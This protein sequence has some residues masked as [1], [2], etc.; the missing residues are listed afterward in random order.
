M[1]STTAKQLEIVATYQTQAFRFENANGDVVVGKARQQID[2]SDNGSSGDNGSNG[3]THGEII[4]IKG[5]EDQGCQLLRN[6][7]YRFFGRWRDYTNRRT[8]KTERQFHFDSY[9][10]TEPAGRDAVVAYLLDAAMHAR[11]RLRHMTGSNSSTM[12]FGPAKAN[13]IW[14]AFGED[15]IRMCREQPGETMVAAGIKSRKIAEALQA[16][17]ESRKDTERCVMDLMELFAGRSIPKKIIQP[18]LRVWGN[19]AAKL[20]RRNPYLLMRFRGVGFATADKMYLGLGHDPKR[21]K[22]LAYRIWHAID[23]AS[24]GDTWNNS[25]TVAKSITGGWSVDNVSRAMLLAR[26]A[27]LIRVTR[28]DDHGCICDRGGK[29][30]IAVRK[31]AD[32]E[33]K[34]AEIIA[35]KVG[36]HPMW[37]V[38]ENSDLTDHQ[39]EAIDTALRGPISLLIGSPGCGKTYSA[40]RII[41]TVIEQYGRDSIA[42]AAPTGKA[43]VRLSESL[44]EAGIEVKAKTIH[45][46]LRV[47]EAGSNGGGWRFHHREDQP[48]PFGFLVID[49]SSMIDVDLMA[50]L[51]RA[52]T[53]ETQLLFIGDTNQLAPV[54]HGAPLRDMIRAGLPCGELRE[55]LRNDGG[56]VQAC[57]DIRDGKEFRCGGNL[58]HFEGD[59]AFASVKVLADHVEHTLDLDCIW[60]FQVIVPINEKSP[61]S[62]KKLNEFMQRELNPHNPIKGSPFRAGDKI[63]NTSNSRFPELDLKTGA[64]TGS[65]AYV[66]NGELGKVIKV[67]PSMF[68]VRLWAPDRLILVPRG[69]NASDG[70]GCS[71]D[72]GYALSCHRCQGSEWPFTAVVIDE[73]ASARR[74]CDRSWIY[75]ALSRAKKHCW[76]IGKTSVAHS[77]CRRQQLG[78]RKTFLVER[79]NEGVSRMLVDSI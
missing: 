71:W 31:E 7:Q 17:L 41:E 37:P 72:L 51:L 24:G 29:V 1:A 10:E 52:T 65:D 8:G 74:V 5:Q 27:G 32:N 50:A 6:K 35:A 60:D 23:S 16:E 53:R 22:R 67:E 42:V 77:M 56:I 43:A 75:T 62:R 63:V 18:C 46:L 57:A 15:S 61:V 12:R 34:V 48:L 11:T 70:S 4:T 14:D 2:E 73:S 38:V 3:S 78:K 55:I 9:V 13:K 45:S 36:D 33:R 59:D 20:I 64:R 39:R 30:Y 47:E 19:Q 69:Q 40:A 28:I 49:E 44:S 54:G 66:A 58:Q 68:T 21:L 26:R 76:L 79:V 25:D